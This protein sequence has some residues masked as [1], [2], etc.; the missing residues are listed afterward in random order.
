MASTDAEIAMENP[1]EPLAPYFFQVAYVI[2]NLEESKRWFGQV[3]GINKFRD[4]LLELR[5]PDFLY[6]GRRSEA[7]LAI[8]LADFNGIQLELIEPLGEDTLW[9]DFL[10]IN[11]P[12]L[13]HVAFLVPDYDRVVERFR[14]E[15]LT[16]AVEGRSPTS[17]RRT[18]K[19]CYF[20]CHHVGASYVEIVWAADEQTRTYI[21]NMAK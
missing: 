6:N 20:D 4:V 9:S 8:A 16:P 12:G 21:R 18:I 5:P 15:G 1:L 19:F 14:S 2:P 7:R 3:Y 10:K 17:S 13:Q 11:G